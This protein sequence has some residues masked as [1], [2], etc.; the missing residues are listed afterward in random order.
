[1]V[2]THFLILK[3]LS[4][5]FHRVVWGG[6]TRIFHRVSTPEN[7]YLQQGSIQFFYIFKIELIFNLH[8]IAFAVAVKP[9]NEKKKKDKKMNNTTDAKL[10][11]R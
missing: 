2:E 5:K 3:K 7:L 8:D 6:N 9:E 4:C 10:F 11:K 1:M